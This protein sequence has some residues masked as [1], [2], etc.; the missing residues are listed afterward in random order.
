MIRLLALIVVLIAIA[1]LPFGVLLVPLFLGF[2][3]LELVE[4]RVKTFVNKLITKSR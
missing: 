3:G 4:K 2:E 1:V